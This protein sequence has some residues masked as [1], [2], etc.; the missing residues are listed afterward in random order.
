MQFSLREWALPVQGFDDGADQDVVLPRR[1]FRIKRR[2]CRGE[3]CE[4]LGEL[5]SHGRALR[6]E[7]KAHS[8]QMALVLGPELGRMGS[9]GAM[10]LAAVTYG[11][12]QRGNVI[13]GVRRDRPQAACP[14]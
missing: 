10:R 6:S 8:E 7:S 9:E 13:A 2:S 11:R 1:A 5:I 14:P 3:D 4:F 12:H